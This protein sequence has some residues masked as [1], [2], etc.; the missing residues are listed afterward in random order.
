M[1][2]PIADDRESIRAGMAR[3]ARERARALGRPETCSCDHPGLQIGP[4]GTL[5][6]SGCRL[7][8]AEPLDLSD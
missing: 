7:A 8:K 5:V 6:C 2:E 4:A 3:L 1:G